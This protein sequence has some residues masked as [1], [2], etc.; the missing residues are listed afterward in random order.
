LSSSTSPSGASHQRHCQAPVCWDQLGPQG[1]KNQTFIEV[2][3][4]ISRLIIGEGPPDIDLS[5]AGTR[6]LTTESFN[7]L[8]NTILHMSIINDGKPCIGDSGAPQFLGAS[9]T[10][11]V[12]DIA[13]D[14]AC[15]AWVGGYR[16]DAPSARAFLGHYV[17]LP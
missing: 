12:E 2:G 16:L 9:N 5:S 7:S 6:R 11:A 14:R 17:T 1:L 3:Y 13:G 10:I 15:T 4:G 8:T